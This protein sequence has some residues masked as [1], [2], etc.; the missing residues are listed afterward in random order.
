ME[1]TRTFVPTMM[2]WHLVD[3]GDLPE[4]SGDY[5]CLTASGTITTVHFSCRHQKF[6][7]R[8]DNDDTSCAIPV[9]CWARLTPAI[10]DVLD[11]INSKRSNQA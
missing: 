3:D 6:N 2:L 1:K 8:D 11:F 10:A 4:C 7:A 5:I 9:N